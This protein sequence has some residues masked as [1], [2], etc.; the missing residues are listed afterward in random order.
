MN[1][2]FFFVRDRIE[3]NDIFIVICPTEDMLDDFF[4]KAV[5]GKKFYKFRKLVIYLKKVKDD[6]VS[7]PDWP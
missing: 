7:K 1:V 3:C 6:F 4:T 5:Q 2:R